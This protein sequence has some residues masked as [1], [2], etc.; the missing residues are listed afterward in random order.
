MKRLAFFLGL[1]LVPVALMVTFFVLQVTGTIRWLP[2]G[3][4]IE[5]DWG[6]YALLLGLIATVFASGWYDER[7]Y[8]LPQF[9]VTLAVAILMTLPVMM[10]PFSRDLGVAPETFALLSRVTYVAFHVANGFLFGGAWT[11]VVNR[12]RGDTQDAY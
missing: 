5:R 6:H 3:P 4:E 11:F 9:L 8:G 12:F 2:V 1:Y 10:A 7:E